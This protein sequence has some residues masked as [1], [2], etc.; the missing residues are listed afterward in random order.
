[1]YGEGCFSARSRQ[2]GIQQGRDETPC[3]PLDPTWGGD[4]T[5]TFGT[6]EISQTHGN[7]TYLR[8]HYSE[9]SILFL[10]LP[11][12][13]YCENAVLHQV[14][15]RYRK[16][17]PNYLAALRH[18]LRT[19]QQSADDV[20]IAQEVRLLTITVFEIRM[21]AP[22]PLLWEAV[23]RSYWSKKSLPA[24]SPLAPELRS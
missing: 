19:Q 1:V 18:S 6:D 8:A 7:S 15:V 22:R 11:I 2:K 5:R 17:R 10:L 13:V 9:D 12:L 21:P 14:R 24:W 4:E 23:E 16:A 20:E 3:L